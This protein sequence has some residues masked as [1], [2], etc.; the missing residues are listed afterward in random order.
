MANNKL[1]FVYNANSG[2]HNAILD[3][4][5]KMLSPETYACNLCDITYGTIKEDKI[6]RKYRKSNKNMV[7]AHNPKGLE[8]QFL[9]KNEFIKKFDHQDDDPYSYPIVFAIINGYMEVFIHT[10]ILNVV[11]TSEELIELIEVKK[12][13]FF[14][15]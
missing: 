2:I 9:H 12:K 1:I 11:E 10:E 14:K 8:M 13:R 7:K 15:I 6:W 4:A 3:S 5:H